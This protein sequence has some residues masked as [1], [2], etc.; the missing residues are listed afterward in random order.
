MSTQSTLPDAEE[1]L[2][3]Q[4]KIRLVVPQTQNERHDEV[5][6]TRAMVPINWALNHAVYNP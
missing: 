3:V 1:M 5:Y 2:P 6:T 4:V